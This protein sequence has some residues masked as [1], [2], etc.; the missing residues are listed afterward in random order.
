MQEDCGKTVAKNPPITMKMDK[1][2]DIISELSEQL[3]S[4]ENKLVPV[5]GMPVSTPTILEKAKTLEVNCESNMTIF[6]AEQVYRL[7]TITDRV[8]DLLYRCEL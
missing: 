6:L 1:L 3:G 2:H 4:L 7:G 5:L 8:K